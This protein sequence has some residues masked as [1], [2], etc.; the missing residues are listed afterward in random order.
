MDIY[1]ESVKDSKEWNEFM[2]KNKIDESF[3]KQQIETNIYLQRFQE[4][5]DTGFKYQR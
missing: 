5:S 1:K 2:E 3:I 4:K